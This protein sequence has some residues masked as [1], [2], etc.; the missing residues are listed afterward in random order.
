[1][2]RSA[3]TEIVESQLPKAEVVED[4]RIQIRLSNGQVFLFEKTP[5]RE[6]MKEKWV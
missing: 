1:M 2:I 6:D 3:E 4:S 5:D